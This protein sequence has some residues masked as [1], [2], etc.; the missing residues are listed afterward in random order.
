MGRIRTVGLVVKRDRPRAVRLARRMIA[1]LARRGLRVLVDAEAQL[2]GAPAR[3]KDDL[4]RDADLIVVL[5]GDGTL[6]SIA[7]R[8]RGQV[9]ILG[10]NL[11]ELGFLT[12]VVV[13]EAMPMLA[14]V[15]AGRYE[16]DRRMTLAAR[17]LRGNRVVGRFRAL[18]D[19]AITNGALARIIQVTVTV[20]GLPFATYRA[21]GMI[22]ATPTG[23]TAYSLSVGGPIV[24]PT[25]QVLVL[26]PV[27]PHTLSN[28]PVVLRPTAA[29]RMVV[30]P[31]ERDA[32]LTVDGQEGMP[33]SAGDAVEVR[34]GPWPV[35]LVRSP[36]RTYYDVLR[37]KLGWGAR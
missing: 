37:E 24:E 28:R 10:V 3:S 21:D 11:G 22:V 34:R 36:D 19:V 1:W 7:R 6:L 4:A 29:V 14:R 12:E 31:R 17:H 20:D 35:A 16:L 13:R 26:S 9:P 27:S 23:S 32:L 2:P 8:T 18:N 15:V 33:L 5:G 30:G 25:V